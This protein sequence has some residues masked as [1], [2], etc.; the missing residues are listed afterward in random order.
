MFTKD[1]P[2][3]CNWINGKFVDPVAS[4]AAGNSEASSTYLPVTNPFNGKTIGQV[5]ISTAADVEQAVAAA[6]A[7]FPAWSGRTSKDRAQILIRFHGLISK[8][9]DELADMVVLEHGKNKSEA[10]ASVLKGQETVEYAMSLPQLAQGKILEVSRGVTCCD[11]REPLGV[12]ASVVPFN[13]PVMV[14]MWTLPIAIGMGNTMVV[15]PSEKVPFTMCKVVELLKE[16]GLP[17]GVVN[18]VHGTADAVN[19]LIDHPDVKAVTFVGTSH[20]ADLVSQ[21]CHKLGKRV[22]ALGGAKN[23]M[24]A[25]PDCNLEM[26]S[27]DVVNSFSGCSGQRCMAASV[28]LTIGHQQ[29]LLDKIVAKAEALQP[30]SNAGQV[31]PV[32]DQASLDKIRRYIDEAEAGGAKILVDGRGWTQEHA[33]G[34]WVGPTVILHT[35]KHDRALHD[36]IFG[37]VLS[38][39]QVESADEALAFENANPYG[40]AACIYTGSG[41]TA[42]YFTQRFSA[43]MVGVN[44]GVPVPREPFSFGGWNRSRFGNHCDITGDGGIEFFSARRKVTTKWVRQ[45]NASWMS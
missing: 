16:A 6:Q 27:Q 7:A 17:D 11:R 3:L 14:P 10:L 9:L 31:G 33:E 36:E 42:E 41:A 20:V 29:A 37:P 35:N 30:G 45:E 22:L 26:T 43:G 1:Q 12:V 13:F 24:V 19:A 38:I 25:A 5:P 15:K 32:I 39:L 44:I 23:H 40:N 28:L 2:K 34:F 21:R 8:H 18:L 4:T